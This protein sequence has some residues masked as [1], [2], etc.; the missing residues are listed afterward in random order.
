MSRLKIRNSV[1]KRKTFTHAIKVNWLNHCVV[2]ITRTNKQ[3]TNFRCFTQLLSIRHESVSKNDQKGTSSRTDFYSLVRPRKIC[4][5]LSRVSYRLSG[6]TSTGYVDYWYFDSRQSYV[7]VK[8]NTLQNPTQPW[9]P[10]LPV[11]RQQTRSNRSKFSLRIN[12]RYCTI[13]KVI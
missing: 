13:A 8:G 7:V 6:W 11:S 2:A 12:I 5:V 10:A 9:L 4:R 1:V 3:L